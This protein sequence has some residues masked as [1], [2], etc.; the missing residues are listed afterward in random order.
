MGQELKAVLTDLN[1]P[2]RLT[3]VLGAST[4][5]TAALVLGFIFSVVG[6]HVPWWESVL[7][8][9]ATTTL[10]ALFSFVVWQRA[11]TVSSRLRRSAQLLAD[12]E[13]KLLETSAEAETLRDLLVDAVDSVDEGFVLFDASNTLV[14]CNARYRAAYPMIADLLQPGA[15]FAD[16]LRVAAA[17]S[18]A[19]DD[20]QDDD[21]SQ[22]V[23][24]RLYRHLR[25][26]EPLECR[27]ADGRWYRISERPTRAGG[28]V[29][30]LSDITTTKAH[31]QELATKTDV[32]ES[33]FD[34]MAQGVAVFDSQH[35]LV[36]WNDH[37]AAV[38]D[39]P[40]ELLVAGTPCT[41]FADFD[42]ARGLATV[43]CCDL[44]TPPPGCDDS[45][46]CIMPSV[47]E[48]G[49]WTLPNGRHVEVSLNAMPRG[50]RVVTFSD[51]TARKQA[52]S[53]LQH[54]QKMD[55]IGQLAGGIA[56]EFNN[57][58]TSIGGFARMALRSPDDHQRV[59]M[60]LG[61]VTKAAD[62]AASLTSQLLN[63][64]RRSVGEELRPIMLKDMIKDLTSFLRPIL[65]ERVDVYV[66]INDPDT[67]VAADPARLH[68]AI[69]NLCINARDAMPEG[70]DITLT[71]DVKPH[72][73]VAER[74]PHLTG[75]H[76]AC[77]SVTDSGTGIDPSHLDRIF[78]PFF[79][80][81]EQGKGTG[82]GLPMVYSTAEHANGAVDVDS[83]LG[84][85]STFR[86]LLPVLNQ[87]VASDGEEV[88]QQAFDGY[89]LTILLAEDED[90]V[91]R[92][93]TMTLEDADCTVLT[94]TN[95]AEA[96]AIYQD[97]AD[98]VDILISD[99]VMPTMDGPTLARTLLEQNPDLNV[100]LMSGYSPTDDWKPLTEGKGRLFLPKPVDPM[101]LL[102][103]VQAV[104]PDGQEA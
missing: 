95:G 23:D 96:I 80:T 2:L 85:G 52:E 27:L 64:S 20:P 6:H 62:R 54:A 49:E 97:A 9:G 100:I 34:A 87:K 31:Q 81:K 88:D 36:T 53:A 29:K 25:S 56:H 37:L 59:V 44:P 46:D 30:V 43:H 89:G 8:M 84:E 58:L 70:G 104:R 98:L 67:M 82:L 33:T 103:A 22:W 35:C 1:S 101:T 57:M 14:V 26:S 90:S 77:L 74:H 86:L 68:Q 45:T 75:S 48:E 55:A 102:T 99:V 17:R 15:S 91:R 72:A 13:G 19:V 16:I 40:P 42:Q 51:I 12:I 73:E 21:L 5:A 28:I 4:L 69:V 18:G 7:I 92:F 50:G 83:T 66:T 24:D 94:A 47:T 61:E 39:Y 93:I 71:L 76:Y 63:F 32:L 38:M 60:C 78:E 3:W 11:R 10:V 41:A 79:T 65:G